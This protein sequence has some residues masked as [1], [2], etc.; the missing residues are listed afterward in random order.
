[1][2][3]LV[4][5]TVYFL[6]YGLYTTL[7]GRGFLLKECLM[8]YYKCNLKNF[9]IFR[10]TYTRANEEKSFGWSD[11][12]QIRQTS[13]SGFWLDKKSVSEQN[14]MLETFLLNKHWD[15]VFKIIFGLLMPLMGISSFSW[16]RS[17]FFKKVLYPTMKHRLNLGLLIICDLE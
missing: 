12:W 16:K 14:L 2:V 13:S 17:E 1:L 9:I 6:S 3:Q 4:A 7:H 10:T 15:I 5:G 11:R 8:H